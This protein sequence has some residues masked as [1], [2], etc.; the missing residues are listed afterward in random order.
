MAKGIGSLI[1]TLIFGAIGTVF[2]IS[3][4][5]IANGGV[6]ASTIGEFIGG[7]LGAALAAT[8]AVIAAIGFGILT[9]IFLIITIVLMAR[10]KK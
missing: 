6:E 3:Y 1:F 2:L 8:F 4:F 5:R 7:A 10:K 9:F